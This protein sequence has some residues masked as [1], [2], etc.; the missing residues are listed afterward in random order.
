VA[1]EELIRIDGLKE[2]QRAL[3]TVSKDA[4]KALRLAGNDAANLVVNDARP[5][6]PIGPAQGGHAVSSI[7]AASTRTQTRVQEG[8]NRF[9]YMPWL[10]FGGMG[11][12]DK[13]NWRPFVKKGTFIWASFV[14]NRQQVQDKL[15]ESLTQVIRS[16]GL[17]D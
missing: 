12:R 14:D 11:G 13:K 8:G 17:G 1:D 9:P 15:E 2:L 3:K 6:V 10:D 7:K 5:R 4:P 16:S